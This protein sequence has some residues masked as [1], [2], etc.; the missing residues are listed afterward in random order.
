MARASLDLT[1]PFS[2]ISLPVTGKILPAGWVYYI[3]LHEG[4]GVVRTVVRS[5]DLGAYL[6]PKRPSS[7]LTDVSRDDLDGRA[8]V[9][10]A[11]AWVGKLLSGC[12]A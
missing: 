8:V 9:C 1:R 3:P 6:L 11:T 5:A 7:N 10:P 4:V 2:S 12:D